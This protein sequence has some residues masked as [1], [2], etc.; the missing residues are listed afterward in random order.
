MSD[1][2]RA[3]NKGRL[4]FDQLAIDRLNKPRLEQMYREYNEFF[5]HDAPEPSWVKE[6]SDDHT[7]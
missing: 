1:D 3:Y 4:E 7:G 6:V 5:W 2:S